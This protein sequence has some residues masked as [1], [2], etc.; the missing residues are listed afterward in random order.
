V[1]VASL[2]SLPLQC[3]TSPMPSVSLIAA[4]MAHKPTIA[5]L[6]QL[7]LHDMTEFMPFPVGPD[8]RFEYGF[9]DR[10]WQHPYLF[11]V[12]GEI[13]GFALVV[14]KCPLTQ[15]S[16]CHFMAEFFVLK[17]YRERGVGRAGLA[18]ILANHPG[19][20][21]IGVPTLNTAA[22]AFWGRA[23]SPLGAESSIL[24]FEGDEWQLNSFD[25]R[26]IN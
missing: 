4:T 14:D 20:W 23:L 22:L 19:V 2:V 18:N 8:G 5:N 7:Y 24:K 17:A 10:F 13:A 15:R 26:S 25:A 9:L 1:K 6:I 21:H 16:P 3:H 12:N 11:E